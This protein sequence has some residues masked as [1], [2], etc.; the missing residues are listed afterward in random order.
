VVKRR[1]DADQSKELLLET[2]LT[3]LKDRGA[4]KVTVAAVA[5]AA[6]CAKGL[7][8]YHF[9][10]KQKLWESVA[11]HLADT[12]ASTWTTA[13]A[14]PTVS[15]AVS[16]SWDLLVEE[17]ANGTTLAWISLSGPGSPLPDHSVNAMFRGF[18][19]AIGGTLTDLLQS[20]SVDLRVPID[21][22]TALLTSVIA[23]VGLHLLQERPEDTL[24]NAYAAA[25]LGIL[26]LG[27]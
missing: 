14:V 5:E 9:K 20:L 18:G 8:H 3:L 6:G 27:S 1:T 23:G 11:R 7:V 2:A 24:E 16:R 17:S 10:T 21:E 12:R 19:E 4:A 22:V 26:S 25:W 15:E 13:L